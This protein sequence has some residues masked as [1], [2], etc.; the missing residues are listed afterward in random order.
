LAIS[1]RNSVPALVPEQMRDEQLF[2]ERSAVDDVVGLRVA[3]ARGVDEAGQELL[4]R[5][6]LAADQD[7]P[8]DP[9]QFARFLDDLEEQSA[10]SDSGT[11]VLWYCV[12]DRHGRDRY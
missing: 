4:A 6:A 1:S 3:S 5:A 2:L 10:G 12:A 8:R 7:R 9:R 11:A